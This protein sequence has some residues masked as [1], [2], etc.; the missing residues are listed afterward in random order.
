MRPRTKLPVLITLLLPLLLSACI[1]YEQTIEIEES[2]AGRMVLRYS[3]PTAVV[4]MLEG[5]SKGREGAEGA[6][7]LVWTNCGARRRRSPQSPRVEL[8]CHTPR[9]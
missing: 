3:A 9:L 8:A 5:M 7:L 4:R 1:E 2:G 6:S